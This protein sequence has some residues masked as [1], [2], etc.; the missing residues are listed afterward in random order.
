MC[1]A[2]KTDRVASPPRSVATPSYVVHLHLEAPARRRDL[3]WPVIVGDDELYP[4]GD[5][6]LDIVSAASIACVALVCSSLQLPTGS[7][8]GDKLCG[9]Q[10]SMY[11]IVSV[12]LSFASWL[13]PFAFF[14][15]SCAPPNVRRQR[16]HL[17]LGPPDHPFA[18]DWR[19]SCKGEQGTVGPS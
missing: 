6:G 9:R 18:G 7:A 17:D 19:S 16:G 1:C 11:P 14:C 12:R 2:H 13:V 8:S 5:A 10:S 3:H 15:G 4:R